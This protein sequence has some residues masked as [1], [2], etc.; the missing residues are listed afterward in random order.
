MKNKKM[1]C[2]ACGKPSS[3][4]NM[5]VGGWCSNLHPECLKISRNVIQRYHLWIMFQFMDA[6]LIRKALNKKRVKK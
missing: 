5:M 2:S 4:E 3:M 6:P 1:V